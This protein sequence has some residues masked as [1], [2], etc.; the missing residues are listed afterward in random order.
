LEVEKMGEVMS[1]EIKVV[2]RE[3]RVVVYK[4]RDGSLAVATDDK[5]TFEMLKSIFEFITSVKESPIT[6]M[7]DGCIDSVF[8]FCTI[9][10][11]VYIELYERWDFE[12]WAFED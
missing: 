7:P 8:F 2:S 1:E 12:Q 10:K 9:D 6:D 3:N 5:E 11:K 4:E